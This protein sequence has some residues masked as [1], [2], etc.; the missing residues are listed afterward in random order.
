MSESPSEARAGLIVSSE[1]LS[2]Q[3]IVEILGIEPSKIIVKGTPTGQA[4]FPEHPFHIAMFSPRL[5]PKQRLE[6][7]LA[8]VLDICERLKEALFT[9]T[10]DCRISVHCTYLVHQ[11]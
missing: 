8:A 4:D 7:H 6:K 10:Q 1:V 9:L 5:D 2:G 3:R 11:E